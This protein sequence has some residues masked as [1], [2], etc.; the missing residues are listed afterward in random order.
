MPR[1]CRPKS[2][3]IAR[4][5]IVNNARRYGEPHRVALCRHLLSCGWKYEDLPSTSTTPPRLRSP[6]FDEDD[7][8]GADELHAKYSFFDEEDEGECVDEEE[9]DEDADVIMESQHCARCH[10]DFTLNPFGSCVVPHVYNGAEP[11]V[12]PSMLDKGKEA[13]WYESDCC[14]PAVRVQEDGRTKYAGVERAGF[15]FIGRHT[16]SAAEVEYNGVNV[17]KCRVGGLWWGCN[18]EPLVC[19]PGRPVFSYQVDDEE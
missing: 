13:L 12:R 18:R 6:L 9:E 14:G 16:A 19:K 8:E 11:L 15:C 1:E 2:I 5:A 17:L 7:L 10:E 4:H 3:S